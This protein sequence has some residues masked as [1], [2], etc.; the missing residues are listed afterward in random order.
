MIKFLVLPLR[1]E[2]LANE[3]EVDDLDPDAI[4]VLRPDEQPTSGDPSGEQSA[5]ADAELEAEF[6][7]QD[8]DTLQAQA[9]G[10]EEILVEDEDE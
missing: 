3:D 8:A 4:E 9:E 2:Q 5:E 7:G 10:D 6:A 1:V